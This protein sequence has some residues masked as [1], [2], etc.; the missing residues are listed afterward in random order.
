MKRIVTMTVLCLMVFLFVVFMVSCGKNATGIVAEETPTT[1]TIS[2]KVITSGSNVG[3]GGA[4]ITL[5]TRTVATSAT[6][7]TF[8][9]AGV[10]PGNEILKATKDD[11]VGSTS[12]AIIAGEVAAAEI[13]IVTQSGAVPAANAV[14]IV[15]RIVD[16]VSGE[17]VDGVA[18]VMSGLGR[19]TMTSQ[20]DVTVAEMALAYPANVP[21]PVVGPNGPEH[22]GYFYFENIAP[23]IHSFQLTKTGYLQKQVNVEIKTTSPY[24]KT[25][26]AGVNYFIVTETMVYDPRDTGVIAGYVNF[27]ADGLLAGDTGGTTGNDGTYDGAAN[28][29]WLATVTLDTG[30]KTVTTNVDGKVGYFK[31]ENIRPRHLLYQSGVLVDPGYTVTASAKRVIGGVETEIKGSIIYVEVDAAKTTIVDIK[32][33]SGA[34]ITNLYVDTAVLQPQSLQK[35]VTSTPVITWKSNNYSSK[36]FLRVYHIAPSPAINATTGVGGTT[37]EVM[38]DTQVINA[39]TY[40]Y[41]GA[42]LV[43]GEWYAVKVYADIQGVLKSTPGIRFQKAPYL[44]PTKL[45]PVDGDMTDPNDT[46]I[47]WNRTDATGNYVVQIYTS[48]VGNLLKCDLTK[49]IFQREVTSDVSMVNLTNELLL[50]GKHY[51]WVVGQKNTAFNAPTEFPYIVD[52]ADVDGDGNVAESVLDVAHFVTA[53][54]PEVPNILTAS[55]GDGGVFLT[56][57]DSQFNAGNDFRLD[58]AHANHWHFVYVDEIDKSETSKRMYIYGNGVSVAL[59]ND[60][61]HTVWVTSVNEYGVESRFVPINGTPGKAPALVF[62]DWVVTPAKVTIGVNTSTTI[63]VSVTLDNSAGGQSVSGLTITPAGIAS[64]GTLGAMSPVSIANVSVPAK[65]KTTVSWTA[66]YTVPV[67]QGAVGDVL[68]VSFMAAAAGGTSS[69]GLTGISATGASGAKYAEITLK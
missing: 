10:S 50:P 68:S 66:L 51:W 35:I 32:L 67:P 18:M 31:F 54:Q 65:G 17:G 30:E 2:G 8:I 9:V 25:S 44:G 15:G 34:D 42:N 26:P 12:V 60:S 69:G 45:A 21:E 46:I 59:T 27:S 53:P 28:Q 63:S 19:S 55:W 52:T 3:V 61:P 48:V 13:Q 14:K 11:I 22:H 16:A 40:T 33:E 36:F 23:G 38:L 64:G 1:G 62:T 5:G 56:W 57:D 24:Y 20:W 6:D 49:V 43:N 58:A 4:I 37:S 7:G 29:E 39:Q 47:T 41:D